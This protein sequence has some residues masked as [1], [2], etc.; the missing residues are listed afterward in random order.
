LQPPPAQPAQE[1]G[2]ERLSPRETQVLRDLAL[3]FT[4]K[5]VAER[6]AVSVKSVETYRARL[7]EKLGLER[8]ADLVRYAIAH[9]LMGDDDKEPVGA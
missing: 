8:R 5:E 6:L 4:N 7:F 9:N 1:T 3:G 2:P